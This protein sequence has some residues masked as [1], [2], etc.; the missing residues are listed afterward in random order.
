ME[1]AKKSSFGDDHSVVDPIVTGLA[2]KDRPLGTTITFSIGNPLPRMNGPRV[3]AELVGVF[4]TAG[5]TIEDR[6]GNPI[7]IDTD[8]KGQRFSRP[9]PGPLADLKAGKNTINWSM[10]KQLPKVET[11]EEE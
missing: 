2:I 5:Q 8:M 6:D 10:N 1:G 9:I 4:P 11:A 3:N 7:T